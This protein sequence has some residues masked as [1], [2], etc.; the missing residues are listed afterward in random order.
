MKTAEQV[1]IGTVPLV[2][3]ASVEAC[4]SSK[5]ASS[6]ETPEAPLSG[7]CPGNVDNNP[8][9]GHCFQELSILQR[10]L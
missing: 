4:R 10:M 5:G 2:F 6:V 9:Y 3:A 8:F 1:R 7:L